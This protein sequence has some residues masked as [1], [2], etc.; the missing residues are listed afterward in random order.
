MNT[1][2]AGQDTATTMLPHVQEVLRTAEQEL[3]GLLQRRAEVMKRIGTIKQMLA[4]LADL[5]GDSVLS[6]ELR[7]TLDRGISDRKKGFTRACRQILMESRTP[8]HPRQCCEELWRRF[9]EVA[10]R[11]KDLGA[12]VT[13]VFHRLVAYGEARCFLD[14]RGVRVWEWMAEAKTGSDESRFVAPET[15]PE[16]PLQQ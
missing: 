5:F 16:Q 4:G 9:P 1:I 11:H 7:I 13:T 15:V 2:V 3:A 8:L 10:G 14:E 6:D 12:S